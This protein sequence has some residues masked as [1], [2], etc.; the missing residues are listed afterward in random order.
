MCYNKIEINVAPTTRIKCMSN[1]V[2][3]REIYYCDV[4][5]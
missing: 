4:S 5:E 1:L 2:L 3:L